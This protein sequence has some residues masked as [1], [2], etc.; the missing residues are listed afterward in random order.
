MTKAQLWCVLFSLFC[1]KPSTHQTFDWLDQYILVLLKKVGWFE[2]FGPFCFS[3]K[4]LVCDTETCSWDKNIQ[5]LLLPTIMYYSDNMKVMAAFL[6]TKL[7]FQELVEQVNKKQ[8]HTCLF[9]FFVSDFLQLH[10][11]VFELLAHDGA[12]GRGD[13]VRGVLLGVGRRD[14]GHQVV[15]VGWVHL[16]TRHRAPRLISLQEREPSPTHAST[17]HPPFMNE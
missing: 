16:K 7:S 14:D 17:L 6:R 10:I 5:S 8:K 11:T 1:V 4:N 15:S 12:R 13:V 3:Q 9:I 2:E